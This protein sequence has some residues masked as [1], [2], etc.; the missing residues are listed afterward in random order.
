[1]NESYNT[2]DRRFR[3]NGESG[4]ITRV[5][6]SE[7]TRLIK[8]LI[9]DAFPSVAVE[10]EVSNYV[11]H[12]SGHRYFTLKDENSQLRCV[13]F[14]WQA[15]GLDFTPEEGMKVLAVGNATV[16]ER[17][18]QYQLTVSRLLPLGRGE[19]LA[20]L[21]ELKSRLA[22]EGI[23][24]NQRPIPPFPSTI[25]VI[26]S[27]T[28]A[29]IRDIISVLT[30]RA[31][32][33][34]I[35]LRPTLVQGIEAAADIVQGIKEINEH[36]DVDVLI[37]GRGG[38]SIEDLWCFNEEITARGIFSSKIPVI[39]AVGHETDFTL[40]DFAADLRA[41]TPSAAAELAVSDSGEL[42]AVIAGYRKILGQ[43]V[44]AKVEELSQRVVMVKKGLSPDRFLQFL[45]LKSQVVDEL[46][47]RIKS[48]CT[49][50]IADREKTL[51]RLGGK[52]NAMNPGSVLSRGYSI[53]YRELDKRVVTDRKMVEEGDFV[54]VELARG[55]FRAQV[56]PEGGI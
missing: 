21:E 11:H 30:R 25:G 22:G 48:A 49:G 23:F 10:G 19:L 51:E 14:K 1:M 40:A 2:D 24:D 52:L 15:Q 29:A 8:E 47:L 6:V 42:L 36:T 4:K 12:T 28:G 55:G 45:M 35:I 7:F 31:P 27:P 32:H 5:T 3:E 39:S 53:V 16:Y 9:E 41:P 13:M 26:T 34:S 37:V 56:T 50:V 17:S 43:G 18:G 38:G 46:S 20:R 44:Q 54:S 33:V